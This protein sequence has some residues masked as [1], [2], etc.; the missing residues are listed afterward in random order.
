MAGISVWN[1]GSVLQ[2]A[3]YL[4]WREVFSAQPALPD[5]YAIASGAALEVAGAVDRLGNEIGSAYLRYIGLSYRDRSLT[6]TTDALGVT[7]ADTMDVTYIICIRSDSGINYSPSDTGGSITLRINPDA[8]SSGMIPFGWIV[9][10]QLPNEDSLG[11]PYNRF[12]FAGGDITHGET[13]LLSGDK[14]GT[15]SHADQKFVLLPIVRNPVVTFDPNGGY[16]PEEERTRMVAVGEALGELPVPERA[17]YTFLGWFTEREGGEMVTESTVSS[18]DAV[19]YAHWEGSVIT[20]SFDA[21][22]GSVNPALAV[23]DIGAAY[24]SLPTPSRA[25]SEF[26]GWYTEPDGGGERITSATI[27]TERGDH[28]LYAKWNVKTGDLLYYGDALIFDDV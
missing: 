28:T 15:S 6:F 7:T 13:I 14:L 26:D 8:E 5:G 27:V 4:Y 3:S 23:V 1:D 2:R 22:R 19:Y 16:L 24:G 10:P 17:E 20:V 25:L 12:N 21:Q 9:I 11:F 18:G